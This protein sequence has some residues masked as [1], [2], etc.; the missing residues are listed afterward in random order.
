MDS[1]SHKNIECRTN[2]LK[3]HELHEAALEQWEELETTPIETIHI[4]HKGPLR[5]SSTSNNHCL[6]VVDAFSSFIGVYPIK[7]TS[8]QATITALEKWITSNGVSQKIIHD[9]D[10]VRIHLQ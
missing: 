1:F 10:K 2:K 5:S 8:A 6:V 9:N 4:D 7:N 3:C